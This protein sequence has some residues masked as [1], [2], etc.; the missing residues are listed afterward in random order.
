[1][2][3]LLLWLPFL[4]S[5]ASAQTTEPP[6]IITEQNGRTTNYRVEGSLA[7]TRT[8]GCIALAQAQNTFTPPDLY[9]GTLAC[10]TQNNPE[11]AVGLFALAGLYG[12][13]DAERVADTSAGQAK[14]VLIMNTF[15]AVSAEQKTQF[16]EAFQRVTGDPQQLAA[17]CAAV[18]KIGLPDYYPAYMVLHGIKAFT[19]NPQ[20][21]TLRKDFEP[22]KTWSRLQ[23]AYL[24]CPA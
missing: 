23:T 4:G 8:I 5:V 13:F 17:L 2:R 10:I 9:R 11:A 19:G 12:R 1:M 14:S 15:A 21:A 3:S 22:A 20:D 16:G 6:R 24:H 18:Q 7:S